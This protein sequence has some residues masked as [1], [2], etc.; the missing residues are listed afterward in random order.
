[1]ADLTVKQQYWTEQLQQADFFDGSMVQ[2]AQS[3]NIS[4]KNL[5]RW[6]NY[7]RKASTAEHKAKSV[8][9]QVVSSPLLDSCLNLKMGNSQLEFTRLPNPQWLA[10]FIVQS[11]AP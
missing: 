10:E 7:F 2:Y 6:R 8:F 1:M 5:Y 4:V 3:K 11:N 9:T